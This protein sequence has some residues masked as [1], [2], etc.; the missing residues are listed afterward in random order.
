M[1]LIP[2]PTTNPA[3]KAMGSFP[4]KTWIFE[5]KPHHNGNIQTCDVMDFFY[6]N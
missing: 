6:F 3:G 5:Y 2:D 4:P 1:T